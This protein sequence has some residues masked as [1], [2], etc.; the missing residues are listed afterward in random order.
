METHTRAHTHTH[1][2]RYSLV[3]YTQLG[4]N[5]TTFLLA[6]HTK[7]VD[8]L[9]PG[10]TDVSCS[11]TDNWQPS[12]GDVRVSLNQVADVRGPGPG[13]S[14]TYRLSLHGQSWAGLGGLVIWAR[15]G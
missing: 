3:I 15:E 7:N 13:P 6:A 12:L 4:L 9:F 14:G 2:Y 8:S 10:S 5:Q 11:L 1:T